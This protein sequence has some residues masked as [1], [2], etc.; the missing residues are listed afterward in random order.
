MGNEIPEGKWGRKWGIVE[1]ELTKRKL[2]LA[3]RMAGENGPFHTCLLR[4]PRRQSPGRG[5]QARR[6]RAHKGPKAPCREEGFQNGWG[7]QHAARHL[8]KQGCQPGGKTILHC[9]NG[10]G[11]FLCTSPA[12]PIAG[13]RLHVASGCTRTVAVSA[14]FWPVGDCRLIFWPFLATFGHST[15]LGHFLVNS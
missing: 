10:T 15:I 13:P 7:G 11:Q 4:S 3:L 1:A 9:E 5:C 6:M 2:G 12:T 8:E 14:D